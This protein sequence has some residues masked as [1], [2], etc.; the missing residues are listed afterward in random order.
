MIQV[1]MIH[2]RLPIYQKRATS[3]RHRYAY[4]PAK[5]RMI[6]YV[7]DPQNRATSQKTSSTHSSNQHTHVTYMPGRPPRIAQTTCT[8]SP[9]CSHPGTRRCL[10]RSY[11]HTSEIPA[12]RYPMTYNISAASKACRRF[13]CTSKHHSPLSHAQN[14]H[15]TTS[16]PT[17]H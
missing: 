15:S 6:M 8:R 12:K 5:S 17:T 3:H 2:H 9:C 13:P 1:P 7:V 16:T 10:S 14:L 4:S 11:T